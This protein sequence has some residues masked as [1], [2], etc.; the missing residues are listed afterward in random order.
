MA[1]PQ[2]PYAEQPA[3]L[4]AEV[5]MHRLTQSKIAVRIALACLIPVVAFTGFACNAVIN[6]WTAANAAGNVVAVIEAA[7]A[8]SNLIHEAQRER[9]ASATFVNS[10]GQS[11]GDVMRNQRVATDKA[12]E[13]WRRQIASVDKQSLGSSFNKIFD[14]AHAAIATLPAKRAEVDRL[15]VS[16]R[17]TV[18]FFTGLIAHLVATADALSFITDDPASIRQ[19]NA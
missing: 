5:R 17:E 6:K 15:S 9:G 16:G 2:E 3:T 8:I 12:V 10:K 13:V 1:G 4:E 7:P 11:L 19:A 18:Q 14:E